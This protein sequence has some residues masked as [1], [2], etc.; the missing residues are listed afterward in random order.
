MNFREHQDDAN[1]LYELYLMQTMGMMQSHDWCP[2]CG[3]KIA[4]S[5]PNIQGNKVKL[6]VHCTRC[7]WHQTDYKTVK[8][9]KAIQSEFL[10]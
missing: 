7:N 6:R 5:L 1:N 3:S 4:G 2:C 8:Y 10:S 9:F